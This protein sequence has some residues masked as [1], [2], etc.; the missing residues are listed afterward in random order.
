MMT[1]PAADVPASRAGLPPPR[2]RGGLRTDL[3]RAQEQLVGQSLC[4]T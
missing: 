4:S 1:P 3:V 2:G